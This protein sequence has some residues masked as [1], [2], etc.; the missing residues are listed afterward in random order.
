MKYQFNIKAFLQDLA[1]ANI[2]DN[3]IISFMRSD[4]VYRLMNKLYNFEDNEDI[5]WD[6]EN[7]ILI[8]KTWCI[9]YKE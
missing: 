9:P 5:L 1:K 7:H 2:P 8:W 6:L 4:W 3:L